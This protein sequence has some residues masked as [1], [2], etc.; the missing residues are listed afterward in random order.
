MI[1]VVHG[2]YL[3]IYVVVSTEVHNDAEQ[4]RDKTELSHP[5]QIDAHQPQN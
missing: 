3:L 2:I 1:L 4:T 5:R